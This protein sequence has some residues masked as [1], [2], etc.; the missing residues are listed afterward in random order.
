MVCEV[1]DEE[2]AFCMEKSGKAGKRSAWIIDSGASC[3]MTWE[4]VLF[5]EY[6][7]LSGS[8]VKLGDGRT[9]E[10][11]VEGT[12]KV[13]ELLVTKCWLSCSDTAFSIILE[14]YGR[15]ETGR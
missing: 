10:A 15:F 14:I 12:V 7:G 11:M 6:K 5:Y 9:V 3:H 8:T 2:F 1:S 13:S 4:R